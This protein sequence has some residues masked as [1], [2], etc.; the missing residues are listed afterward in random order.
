[1]LKQ[2]I[3]HLSSRI[4]SS[5]ALQDVDL[6][7]ISNSI[8][9]LMSSKYGL[10][11]DREHQVNDSDEA[12]CSKSINRSSSALMSSIEERVTRI[13]SMLYELNILATDAANGNQD[14]TVDQMKVLLQ[15]LIH[16]ECQICTRKKEEC[17]EQHS[18]TG[19]IVS[20]INQLM[21]L[22]ECCGNYEKRR[23]EASLDIVSK[24][25][26]ARSVVEQ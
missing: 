4:D 22:Q 20:L 18:S 3:D 25:S 12:V 24:L 9:E 15:Q 7:D 10:I 13:N 11:H 23:K 21:Q 6:D 1:M 2:A 5:L 17:D 26:R 16:H 14:I 19:D 8:D